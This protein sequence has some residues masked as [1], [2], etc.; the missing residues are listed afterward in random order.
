[1]NKNVTL[2]MNTPMGSNKYEL[3]IVAA[4]E[5]RRL[6]N[7][8]R[9]RGE[10]ETSSAKVTTQALSTTLHGEVPYQYTTG[11]TPAAE[12]VPPPPPPSVDAE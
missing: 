3:A 5:A 4:R 11:R 10:T 12:V 6:N 9:M 8:L 7:A 2:V 1:M